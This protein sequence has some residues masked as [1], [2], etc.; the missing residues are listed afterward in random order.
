MARVIDTLITRFR[1]DSDLREAKTAEQKLDIIRKKMDKFA[2]KAG[3]AGAAFGLVGGIITNTVLSF[4]RAINALSA[5]YLDNAT[6]AQI[7]A[8]K[9][10]AI[11]LG[12]TTSKSATDAANAQVNLARAGLDANEV[13]AA[14]PDVLNLAIAG[15]LDMAEAAQL[16]TG[17]LAGFNLEAT[18]SGRVADVLAKTASSAATTVGEMGPALK[19]VATMASQADLN[20][21]QTAAGI[22]VLRNSS[23][24]AGAAGTGL[25]NVMTILLT[26]PTPGVIRG[27]KQL[28]VSFEEVREKMREGDLIGG[29]RM[30]R[31]GLVSIERKGERAEAMVNIFGREVGIA[32]GVLV[33]GVD[34][35]E[36]FTQSLTDAEGT[37]E[38]MRAIMESGVVGA[39]D[40]MKSAWEGFQLALAESGF[41]ETMA[42][43][44]DL[45]SKFLRLMIDA[46]GPVKWFI[47]AVI[48]GG[49]G[50]GFLAAAI[51]IVSFVLGV[52]KVL[53][54]ET[55]PAMWG[56]ITG[57]SVAG[58]KMKLLAAKT[59]LVTT[60]QAAWNAVAAVNPYVLIILAII[61]T[62]AAIVLLVKHFDKVKR[63]F[64]NVLD[65]AKKNWPLLGAI[66]LG[67]IGLVGYAIWQFK[68][69][70]I[71]ALQS[72]WDF[73]S[74][75]FSSIGDAWHSLTRAV[76]DGAS[77]LM[78]QVRS[79][80]R[81]ITAWYEEH[82]PDW[83]RSGI[84][85]VAG[86][87]GDI[88][89]GAGSLLGIGGGDA[90]PAAQLAPGAT[91][92]AV[93]ANSVTTTNTNTVTVENVQV[94]V[95]QGDAETIGREIGTSLEDE[96]NASRFAFDSGVA[97]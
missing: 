44:I 20:I 57:L 64:A 69:D 81:A 95:E 13:L 18:A 36:A 72:A 32:G 5:T 12:S 88:I 90:A 11:D 2:L 71:D 1:W 17:Q 63:V 39:M 93:G 45:L 67:P 97:R 19:N 58:A 28:G 51:E 40:A 30:M 87:L 96:L 86:G 38:V 41:R 9:K 33:N 14:T 60:A 89:G 3:I 46:P 42:F 56:W 79:I 66:L 35:M 54:L 49:I 16:V 80:F 26:E 37:A 61:A 27:F 68:D 91:A 29:L 43:F 25:R 59:W 53:I 83:L 23:Q 82:V 34:D 85:F 21:E 76:S 22:A 65:W 47:T 77:W 48:A 74:G 70:I 10:Q 15:E 50:L 62:V 8:L 92:R 6:E 84:D 94:N 73:V 75:I 7:E 31:D 24:D 55:I 52:Y 78:E 4:D